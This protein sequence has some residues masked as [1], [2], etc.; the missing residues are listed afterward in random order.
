MQGQEGPE[1]DAPEQ[2]LLDAA[3]DVRIVG[4]P[5][6]ERCRSLAAKVRV[7][8]VT[9]TESPPLPTPL[10]RQADSFL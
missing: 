10:P 7:V 4:D 6:W 3:V 5:D 8:V 2:R 1:V 9:A